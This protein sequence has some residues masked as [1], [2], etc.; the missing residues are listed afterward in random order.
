VFDIDGKWLGQE[1]GKELEDPANHCHALILDG[2]SYHRV[3]IEDIPLSV[4]EVDVLLDDNGLKFDTKMIAGLVGYQ[5]SDTNDIK[6]ALLK[7]L[8]GWWM[9]IKRSQEDL[10]LETQRKAEKWRRLLAQY[11]DI[12][13]STP[14]EADHI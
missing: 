14:L 13:S 3:D 9:Y 4:A 12:T 2:V 10:D 8:P 7:P 5:I 6:G 11:E 1:P